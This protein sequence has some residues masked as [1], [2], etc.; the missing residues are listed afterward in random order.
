QFLHGPSVALR[1]SDHLVCLDGGGDWSERVHAIG[2]AAEQS[3][4]PVTRIVE[5]DLGEPLSIFALTVAVQRIAVESAEAVGTNP[6]S[7]GPEVPGGEPWSAIALCPPRRTAEPL[8]AGTGFPG[9][10]SGKGTSRVLVLGL[11]LACAS[12]ANPR[13]QLHAFRCDLML[14]R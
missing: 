7:F 11:G 10:G 2:D 4:V 8:L 14:G 9:S 6:D 12:R 3:G 5:R 13:A 1:A